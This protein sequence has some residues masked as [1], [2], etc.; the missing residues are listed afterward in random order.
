MKALVKQN[1]GQS[2]D[3][4]DVPIPKPKDGE[5][6]VRVNKVAICGS[7]IALYQW[8]AGLLI[9]HGRGS[10]LCIAWTFITLVARTIAAVPFTPGHEMVGEVSGCYVFVC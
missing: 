8:N 6:L 5:L 1:E 4:V 9:L 7:D 3:Y 2:Y 10:M